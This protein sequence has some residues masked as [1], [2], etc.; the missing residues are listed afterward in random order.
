MSLSELH[1]LR[2]YHL[3][4]DELSGSCFWGKTNSLFFS[5]HW[6]CLVVLHLRMGPWEMSSSRSSWDDIIFYYVGFVDFVG[7]SSLPCLEETVLQQASCFFGLTITPVLP[8]WYRDCIGDGST[9]TRHHIAICSLNVDQ[10]WTSVIVTV[11]KDASLMRCETY[12]YPWVRT[13]T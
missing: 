13:H 2:G 7:A 10:S 3:K 1:V 4:L 5:S 11:C 6:W 8:P 9:E 12:T